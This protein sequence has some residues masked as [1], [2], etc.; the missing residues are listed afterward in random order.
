MG[1]I[2]QGFSLLAPPGAS[3]QEVE[4]RQ[5]FSVSLDYLNSGGFQG[6]AGLP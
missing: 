6:R 3:R 5:G 4:L 2:S 1:W